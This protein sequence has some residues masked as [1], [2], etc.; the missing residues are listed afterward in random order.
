MGQ[1]TVLS[2]LG[3]PLQAEIELTSVSKDEAGNVSVRLAPAAAFRQANIEFNPSLA[4]LRFAVEQ[5]GNRQVVRIT[6]SQPMNEPFVDVLL[7]VSSNGTRLLREYVVLLDPVGSRRAQPAE[8]A[9]APAATPAAPAARQQASRAAPAAAPAQ[10]TETAPGGDSY[11]VKRGDTLAAIAG[12]VKPE[13]VSLD[14]MLVALQRANPNAF[15]GN[16]INRLRTGQILSVPSA[17]TARSVSNGEA[18]RIVVAQSADFNNYRNRLASQVAGSATG[19]GEGGQLASGKVTSRVEEQR[20]TGG[21]SRDRLQVSR[22]GA[23]VSGADAEERIAQEKALAEANSRVKE[24][25]KTVGDLQRLLEIKNRD[26]A[27]RQNQAVAPAAQEKP[28]AANDKP[29]AAA[30]AGTAP[31]S[32]A[33]ATPPAAEAGTPPSATAPTPTPAPTPAADNAASTAAAPAA[34]AAKPAP[35]P[36]I[37]AP[38]PPEPSM[39]EELAGNPAVLGGSALVL[40][41]LAALGITRSRKAKQAKAI[42]GTSIM[43]TSTLKTNSLFGAAGGQSVDTNNSV[44]NSNFSPS[45]SQLDTNEVDP[46]AEADVYIAYGRDAQAEEILKEALRT[47]PDRAAV[48]GKLLEIYAARKDLRAFEATATELF[49]LT[50]GEGEEW[51]QAAILGLSL[52]PANPLYASARKP[53]DAADTGSGAALAAGAGIAAADAS[54][55]DDAHGNEIDFDALLNTTQQSHQ[56]DAPAASEKIDA[57]TTEQDAA[58]PDLTET[59]LAASETPVAPALPDVDGADVSD[60][61]PAPA[62]NHAAEPEATPATPEPASNLLDFDFDLDSFGKAP[63]PTPPA[64]HANDEPAE[65]AP[66]DSRLMD[67][68]LDDLDLPKP[69]AASASAAPSLDDDEFPPLEL[70]VPARPAETAAVH[71]ESAP[72]DFDLSGIS[73]DLDPHGGTDAALQDVPTLGETSYSNAAEMAT[74]LDL[75][76]AYQEIGDR[77]GAREL[78]EEVI[79]GGDNEQS[80]KAK[81]LLARLD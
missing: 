52:D 56:D 58:A 14:Q 8:T 29:A 1:L 33:S 80:E 32:A 26:L 63:P 62:A 37:P 2:A 34:Q 4:N 49:S 22:S 47:Q 79:K 73:L 11:P 42:R 16:N 5:R 59:P 81:V 20:N 75:A 41:L 23:P 38:P 68:K 31:A 78:L 45:A 6:S 18:R 54:N 39:L 44:F 61:H 15:V 55:A 13:G 53:S 69:D 10:S 35:K 3:Q 72:M 7:E 24:L 36:A 17:E 65:A 46:V 25:E 67:F 66:A 43:P 12:Q 27:A 60:L 76:S 74:K 9:P 64:A 48:R 51:A 30:V 50:K 70:D 57:E 40:A 21:E 28:M 77:E 19:Q 71:D